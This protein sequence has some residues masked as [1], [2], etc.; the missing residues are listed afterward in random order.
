MTL[1]EIFNT[2]I[3]IKALMY[4]LYKSHTKEAIDSMK[5]II[6]ELGSEN[7]EHF[8]EETV[9]LLGG[10]KNGKISADFFHKMAEYLYPDQIEYH[11]EVHTPEEAEAFL[12]RLQIEYPQYFNNELFSSFI[13]RD[14][15]L[16][17]C[18]DDDLIRCIY[19]GAKNGNY[20]DKL[21]EQFRRDFMR[22]LDDDQLLEYLSDKAKDNIGQDYLSNCD[23]DELLD[24]LSED[25]KD[26]IGKKYLEYCSD[27]ELLKHVSYEAKDDIGKEYLRNCDDHELFDCISDEAKDEIGKDCL[28]RCDNDVLLFEIRR[29]MTR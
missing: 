5:D 15:F 7:F 12:N 27:Y 2:D 17:N 29:R 23:D 21:F 6:S 24:Y 10:Q 20:H 11:L 19:D 28:S 22:D 4:S 18:D 9:A 16:Q 3:G 25:A 13:D 26:D 14:K 1:K 8:T